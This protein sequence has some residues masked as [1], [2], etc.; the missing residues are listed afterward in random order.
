MVVFKGRALV[1]GFAEGEAV[2]VNEI[3]F[4]GDVDPETGMLFDGR[5]LRDK[6]LV[7]YKPRGST[8]GSYIIYALKMNNVSPKAIIMSSSEPIIVAGCVL[9]GI[10]LV[11]GISINDLK[12]IKDGDLIIVKEG[13]VFVN[14]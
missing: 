1:K 14:E 7:S 11:D 9:S 8:V 12:T 4:Y 3:S 13:L 10:P 2:V 6:I 5:S